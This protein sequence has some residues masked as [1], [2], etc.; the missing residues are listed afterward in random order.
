LETRLSD[1]KANPYRN[2]TNNKLLKVYVSPR[3]LKAVGEL[4]ECDRRDRSEWVRML[5]EREALAD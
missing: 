1:P 3:L 2:Q 4:A 5:L